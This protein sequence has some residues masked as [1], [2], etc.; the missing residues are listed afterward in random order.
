MVWR[1][2]CWTRVVIEQ[3]SRHTIKPFECARKVQN[4][5]KELLLYLIEINVNP[6]L[7]LHFY[8]VLVATLSDIKSGFWR[9][10][11]FEIHWLETYNDREW[12][13]KIATWCSVKSFKRAVFNEMNPVCLDWNSTTCHQYRLCLHSTLIAEALSMGSHVSNSSEQIAS[14]TDCIHLC[15]QLV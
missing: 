12:I 11:S 7:L 13:E 9:K 8:N 3:I 6:I 1:A 14:I 4:K 10:F 15:T 5:W 2:Y